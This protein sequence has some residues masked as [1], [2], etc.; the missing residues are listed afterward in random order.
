MGVPSQLTLDSGILLVWF[1]ESGT[2]REPNII[3]ILDY[4]HM[5]HCLILERTTKNQLYLILNQA[6][7]DQAPPEQAR[8]EQIL[9]DFRAFSNVWPGSYVVQFLVHPVRFWLAC[10]RSTGWRGAGASG[11]STPTAE[12]KLIRND[13]QILAYFLCT[14]GVGGGVGNENLKE[15]WWNIFWPNL[16]SDRILAN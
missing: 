2:S 3:P 5:S 15:S 8:P 16:E 4:M 13:W 12:N 14:G 9:L 6:P 11:N 10:P 7:L 1:P